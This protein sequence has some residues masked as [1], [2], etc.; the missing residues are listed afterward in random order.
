MNISVI[1]STY[2]WVEALDSCLKSLAFQTDKGFEVIVADDGSGE[3]TANLVRGFQKNYPVKLLHAWQE[4]VGFRLAASRNNALKIASGDYCIFLDGDCIAL[5][6]FVY[7]H[8]KLSEKGWFVSGNRTLLSREYTKNILSNNV[9]FNKTNLFFWAKRKLGGDINRLLPMIHSFYPT[10]LRKSRPNDWKMLRGCNFAVWM[11]DLKS[12]NGFDEDFEG[13]GFEDSDISIRLLNSG[14]KNK[15]GKFSTGVLH[16]FHKENK[17]TFRGLNWDI[18]SSRLKN[19][20]TFARNG[21]V[22]I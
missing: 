5:P 15:S 11:D 16:L 21:L 7:Q 12:V 18:L 4:D 8:R 3:D 22:K 13:W 14:L 9:L 6:D 17:K 10:F 19:K 1:V 2:N 20:D